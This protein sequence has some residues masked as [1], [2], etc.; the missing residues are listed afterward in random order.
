MSLTVFSIVGLAL[1]FSLAHVSNYSWDIRSD[2]YY[3]AFHFA[4]GVLTALFFIS[5]GASFA[6]ALVLTMAT[7]LAWELYEWLSWKYV[8]KKKK[9]KPSRQDTMNDFVIDFVGAMTTIA[10]VILNV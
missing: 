7:G 6:L 9:Y 4:G 10:L 5:I 2:R 8:L 3:S 1:L